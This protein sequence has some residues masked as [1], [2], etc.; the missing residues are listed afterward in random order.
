LGGKEGEGRGK[1]GRKIGKEIVHCEGYAP[2]SVT[3][4]SSYPVAYR[5][6]WGRGKKGGKEERRK[7]G[8]RVVTLIICGIIAVVGVWFGRRK[9]RGEGRRRREK[10]GNESRSFHCRACSPLG[11]RGRRKKGGGG[12]SVKERGGVLS[13]S[14]LRTVPRLR[15]EVGKRR[16]CEI[17]AML[18]ICFPHGGG[19]GE[20]KERE[21]RGERKK[22]GGEATFAVAQQ[23]PFTLP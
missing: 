14:D 12:E 2:T 6:S 9:E 8:A 22:G 19:G 5:V 18:L 11:K 20:K 17:S 10:R 15:E 3:A 7:T 13:S 1:R 21:K 4:L 16:N 23:L